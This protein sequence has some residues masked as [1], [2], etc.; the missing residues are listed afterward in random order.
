MDKKQPKVTGV[1]IKYL[2]EIYPLKAPSLQ[3][4]ER[5]IFFNVGIQEVIEKLKRI[6]EDQ[7]KTKY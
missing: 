2:E 5:E 1:L 4:T 6:H 7:K 3:S